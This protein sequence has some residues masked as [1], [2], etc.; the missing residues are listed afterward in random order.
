MTTTQGAQDALALIDAAIDEV[1]SER[2][3][4]GSFAGT[5]VHA[6]LNSLRVS[7]ESLLRAVS[8]V[9]D[10]NM[11][12]VGSRLQRMKVLFEAACTRHN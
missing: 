11:A 4:V 10:A 6:T 3:R 2:A 12:E 9:G 8:A 7:E 5:T 1:A